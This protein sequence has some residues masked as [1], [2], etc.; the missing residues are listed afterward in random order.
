MLLALALACLSPKIG[1]AASD[2]KRK[3]A[4]NFWAGPEIYHAT[5]TR[6]GG[7]KQ[8]GTLLGVAIGYERIQRCR[9]YYGVDGYLAQGQM[10]GHNGFDD[11]ITSNL[12]D[13][14]VEGRF[15]YTWQ[16]KHGCRALL[17]PFIGYGYFHENNDFNDPSPLP[18]TYHDS[19]QYFLTGFIT[20]ATLSTRFDIFTSLKAKYSIDGHSRVT[21]DPDDLEPITLRM[22]SAWQWRV[23]FG[24]VYRLFKNSKRLYLVLAP[25]YEFRHYGGRI[26]YPYDFKD[27]KFNIW[28]GQMLFNCRF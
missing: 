6:Q 27:T 15:G 1:H 22:E 21:N 20:G 23:D 25:F 4:N 3:G 16:L 19:F 24:T 8:K 7:T 18:V 17:I 28:G 11:Y 5:R 14:Q 13:T 12:T 2:P 10:N 9:F 26:S